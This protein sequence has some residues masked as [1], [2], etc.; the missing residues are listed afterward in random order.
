[1]LA[2]LKE[3]L[4][5]LE[6]PDAKQQLASWK[7]IKNS[8]AQPD[9]SV[10]YIHIIDPVVKDADYSIVNIVNEAFK[11]YEEQLAFYELYKGALKQALFTVQGPVVIDMAK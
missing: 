2:T 4:Q 5:K 10:L 3:S 7:V 6:R 11:K 9:G 8:A 1:V